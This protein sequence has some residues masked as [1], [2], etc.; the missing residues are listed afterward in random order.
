MLLRFPS[1]ED[2]AMIV[3]SSRCR[4]V[5]HS[6]DL[7]FAASVPVAVSKELVTNVFPVDSVP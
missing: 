1:A 7:T 5:M 3:R 6:R 2:T 4:G